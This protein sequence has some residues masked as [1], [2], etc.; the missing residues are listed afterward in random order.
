[1]TT[2]ER[3]SQDNPNNTAEWLAHNWHIYSTWVERLEWSLLT[4]LV[5][6]S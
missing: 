4:D 1:M 5:Q 6:F 2:V 3:L